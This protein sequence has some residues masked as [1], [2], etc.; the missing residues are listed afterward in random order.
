MCSVW[1]ARPPAALKRGAHAPSTGEGAGHI[2]G[3]EERAQCDGTHEYI[4]P[5]HM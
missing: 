3:R 2:R 4:L 5:A 1:T